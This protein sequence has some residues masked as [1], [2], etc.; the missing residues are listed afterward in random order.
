ME[1]DPRTTALVAVHCQGDVVEATGAFADFF[2]Q[3]VTE[4]KVIDRIATL[5]TAARTAHTTIVY[6]RV[7]WKPD[8]SD[9]DANS[10]LLGIVAQ[11]GCLKEGS[12]LARSSNPSRR[13]MRTPCSLTSASEPSPVPTSIPSYA[14]KASPPSSSQVWPQTPPSREQPGS[15]AISDTEW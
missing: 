11:S 10:P 4:R 12:E 1:L 14:A 13:M 9:L 5:I 15:Q 3:Q 6:T 2:Y 8:L 7:A